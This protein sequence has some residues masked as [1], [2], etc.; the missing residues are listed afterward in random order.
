M[1]DEMACPVCEREHI[2]TDQETCPQCGADLTCFRVLDELEETAAT[3]GG[4]G[5]VT[6]P[7]ENRLI[8]EKRTASSFFWGILVASA[9][10]I[11]A[12]G[13]YRFWTIEALVKEQ[14]TIFR[15]KVEMVASRLDA[16]HEKQERFASLIE[17]HLETE[18]KRSV[19]KPPLQTD[20]D[21]PLPVDGHRETPPASQ[22]QPE[23]FD[24]TVDVAT[25]LSNPIAMGHAFHVYQATDTDT[26]WGIARRF[27]GA[28][29][30]Y[31]VVLYHNPEL[32]IYRMS[33]K[34]RI[35][36]LKDADQARQI[37]KEIIVFEDNR[38]YWLYTAR[39]GDTPVSIKMRYCPGK[40]CLPLSLD[41]EPRVR[42]RP[43]R[44]IKI[45]LAEGL[46]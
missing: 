17:K 9:V 31:P 22:P 20:G 2:P 12:V 25:E 3:G 26:L 30:Y 46:Q 43:G 37:Y 34:D 27:Y 40:S 4:N 7:A 45:Q 21:H 39:P 32:S 18:G 1:E 33:Q 36:L 28:G 44:K 38:R 5:A 11:F 29:Y 24:D 14:Q 42:I 15:H 23:S 6:E 35:K 8:S 16:A 10:F 41:A 19:E 13:V